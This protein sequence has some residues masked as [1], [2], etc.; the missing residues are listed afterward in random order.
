MKLGILGTGMIVK[1]FLTTI[2]KL[3]L[4]SVYLLGTEQTKEETE[5][6]KEQ[7]HLD[8]TFYD[9]DALLESDADTIYVALPNFLHYAFAKKALEADKNVIIEKPGTSNAKEFRELKAIASEKHLILV[10]AMTVHYMPAYLSI[11]QN[12]DKLGEMKIVSLNYSQYSSRHNSFKEGIILP[13]FDPKK[14]GGALMDINVYNIHFA[15][16]LFGKPEKVEYFANIEKGID[17][18]GVLVLTYPSF[19]V[20]SI[21]A[22]DCKAPVMCSLQ[23]DKGCLTIDHPVNGMT[24]YQIDLNDGEVI[25]YEVKDAQHRMLYEYEEFIRMIDEHDYEK[26]NKMLEVSE[27]VSEVLTEA[28]YHAGIVFPSD[29]E[30]R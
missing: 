11:R 3:K 17:T 8:Q 10:E 23:G 25:P 21:G 20:V 30:Q 22:K 6:L 18:S 16:G 27:I 2:D 5:A 15:I 13:V 4:E 12:L 7:Y 24:S 19:K 29:E 26:A 28:R 9:Y 14:S 1:D